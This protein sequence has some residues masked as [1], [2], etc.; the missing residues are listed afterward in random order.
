MPD[1]SCIYPGK[2]LWDPREILNTIK[3]F[4][5]ME[6]SGILSITIKRLPYFLQNET[7]TKRIKKTNIKMK[8]CF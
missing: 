1:I 6:W 4:H 7:I 5:G 3:L 2:K 8:I